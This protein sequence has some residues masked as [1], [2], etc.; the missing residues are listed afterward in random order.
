MGSVDKGLQLLQGQPMVT[1]VLERLGAQVGSLMLNANR[2][3]ENYA[4]FGHPVWPDAM[5]D[6]AGPLAGLQVGLLHC[7]TPWLISAPCDSPFLPMNLVQRLRQAQQVDDADVAVPATGEN[8]DR[9][10]HPVFCLVRQTLLGHLTNFL[11]S[12]GRKVDAWYSTLNVAQVVFDDQPGAFSNVNTLEEL[13][14]AE[15][16]AAG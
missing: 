13:R 1:H 11:Q 2:N 10:V 12:G 15:D 3:F 8:V 6:F 16:R 14:A 5:T 4:R 7:A 9:Q